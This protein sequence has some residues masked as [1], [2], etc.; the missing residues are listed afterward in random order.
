MS[1]SLALAE[2]LDDLLRRFGRS[3]VSFHALDPDM[4][5][6]RTRKGAVAYVDTGSAWVT[7]GSPLGAIEDW[8][9]LTR[10]F[11]R[12]ARLAH[13]RVC[14]CAT[15]ERFEHIERLESLKLGAQPVWEPRLWPDVVASARA[16]GLRE[17]LRRARAKHVVV[18]ELDARALSESSPLSRD[19]RDLV[20]RWL[21]SQEAAP[22]RFLL[23]VQVLHRAHER[24]TFVA[25]RNGRVVALLGAVPIYARQGWFFR[26]L[27]RD[28]SA[29]NGTSELLFD[30][31]LRAVAT[32]GCE[33]VTMGLV[34]FAQNDERWGR[35]VQLL[36]RR[37]YNFSGLERFRRRL[38]PQHWEP[39]F[40]RYP[41]RQGV[42]FAVWD[43]LAAL[44][45]RNP[46]SWVAASVVRPT[47]R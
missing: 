34:P 33:R 46:L 31:A 44:M 40:L 21:A 32:S 19:V 10:N 17:Q 29:P 27:V 12:T 24:R 28:P 23:E 41:K 5:V 14:F 11:I 3:T 37:F 9:A 15:E 30:A 1:S 42:T 36:G 47:R 43:A 8:P 35:L 6:W 25:L 20:S 39:V 2:P 4:A 22:L 45:G 26:D 18:R 38:L 13:R 7:T 16:K